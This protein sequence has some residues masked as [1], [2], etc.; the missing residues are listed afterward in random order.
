MNDKRLPAKLAPQNVVALID[1]REQLPLC[2]APLRTERATLATGDYTARGFEDEVC[3]E[4][5]SLDD[6]LACVGRER[7]RFERELHRMLA[8][9]IRVLLIEASWD[10]IDRGGWRSQ[11]TVS[12]VSGSLVGWSAMGLQIALVG[13]HERAGVYASRLLYT[14]ARRRYEQLRALFNPVDLTAKDASP[15]TLERNQIP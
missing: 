9:P 15:Q 1:T 8:F 2:L 3:I 13:S 14:V 4:R 12:Q 5:K 7:E 11:V 10:D 6:L